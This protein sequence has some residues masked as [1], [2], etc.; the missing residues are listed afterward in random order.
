M[1]CQEHPESPGVGVCVACR[2]VVCGLCT[3]RLQGRNFCGPCLLLRAGPAETTI[4]RASSQ[5][6]L[7]FG[8]LL[9]TG[10][11]F[12]LVSVVALV[13]YLLHRGG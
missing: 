1:Y 2:K 6:A 13:G 5:A 3:T 9:A 7:L 12:S 4:P 11:L 8:S 10:G